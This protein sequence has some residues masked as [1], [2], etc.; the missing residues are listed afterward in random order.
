MNIYEFR[1]GNYVIFWGNILIVSELNEFKIKAKS[2]DFKSAYEN[3]IEFSGVNIT[4]KIYYQIEKQ[5]INLPF[6]YNFD[7]EK[8]KFYFSDYEQIEF[9]Y[10]HQVQNFYFELT[11]QDLIIEL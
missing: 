7:G 8:L 5:L 11:R 6:S 10:L 9:E 2:I 3:Y 4:K 1:I